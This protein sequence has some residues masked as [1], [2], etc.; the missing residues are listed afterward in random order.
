VYARPDVNEVIRLSQ[1][2]VSEHVITA[3][4]TVDVIP[5]SHV[6]GA[7]MSRPP[8]APVMPQSSRMPSG[9]SGNGAW[10]TAP[11]FAPPPLLER[12]GY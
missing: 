4:Q 9:S 2:G 12:R 8:V 10:N 1:E 7:P 11:R 6:Y 3:I 5:M